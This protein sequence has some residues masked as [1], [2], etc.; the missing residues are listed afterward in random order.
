MSKILKLKKLVCELK[1]KYG[2]D[3]SIQQDWKYQTGD[4][5]ATRNHSAD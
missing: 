2:G 3:A 4:D 1:K 5:K